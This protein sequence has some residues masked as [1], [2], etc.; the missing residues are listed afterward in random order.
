MSH[1]LHRVLGK[2]Y[3]VAASGTGA[4]LRDRDGR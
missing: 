2:T 3:P 4:L 1:V